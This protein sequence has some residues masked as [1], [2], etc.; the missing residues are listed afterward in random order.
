M[1]IS[2]K[3]I[4]RELAK[5]KEQVQE[6]KQ[7]S[8]KFRLEDFLFPEQLAFVMDRSPNKVALC[9]R[10][11]GKTI[12]CAADLIKTSLESDGVVSLYITLSRN[13][14]KKIIWKELK[15]INKTYKLGIK[16]NESELSAVFTNEST[17]YLSGAKDLSEIEK[18]R[19][20]ALKLVYID[21]A[22]SFRTYIEDLVNDALGPAL[23]DYSG[24]LC[25]IGTPPPVPNGFFIDSFTKPNAW[26][27]HSWTFFNNPFITGKSG[28]THEEMLKRVLVTRGVSI[29]DPAIQREYFGKCVVDTNSLLLHY[30]KERNH[31]TTLPKAEHTYVLGVDIGHDD[32]DALAVLAWSE[33]GPNVYLVEEKLGKGQ[34]ITELMNQIEDMRKKYNISKI[35]IDT[36]GLGKK[37]TEELI[38]RHKIP[39]QAADK[40][41]KMENIALLNDY[42]RTG[43]FKAKHD[44]KFAQDSFL[45]EIDRDKSTS[46][47]I[48]VSDRYHSDIIDA[49]LY[50][51]KETFAYT[52]EA[53]P[54]ELKHGTKEWADAQHEKMLEA[55]L[56]GF[57]QDQEYQRR[58]NGQWDDPF[59]F[60]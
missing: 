47:K 30:N 33:A 13:N 9:S 3:A 39:L 56:E 17:I 5:R 28:Q 50:A 14:A 11:A 55:E 49:V 26:A 29:D 52:H 59:N 12:S 38:R 6:I 7:N 2:N 32:A 27:K 41:R 18:F 34:D 43:K 46:D 4:K 40:V 45:V 57:R 53:T 23:M 37:I 22:Q 8:L 36:G 51:F 31:Y 58:I 25:L 16:F 44:S 21:E 20:M 54:P 10:R 19:G 48:K 24:T 1:I 42:L 60:D 15:S 35:V